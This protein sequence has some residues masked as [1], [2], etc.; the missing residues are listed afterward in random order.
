M[1]YADSLLTSS[2]SAAE[3]EI[4]TLNTSSLLNCYINQKHVGKRS[5]NKK[6]AGCTP[7]THTA[8]PAAADK[9]LYQPAGPACVLVLER[10][11]PGGK[12]ESRVRTERKA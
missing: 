9:V 7:C 8:H 2:E 11:P 6:G 3:Q 12:L 10:G 5:E 4:E 1:L